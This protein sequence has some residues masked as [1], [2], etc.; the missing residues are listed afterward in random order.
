MHTTSAKQSCDFGTMVSAGFLKALVKNEN[1]HVN[2]FN[3]GMQKPDG[4]EIKWQC[5]VCGYTHT[6]DQPPARCPRCGALQ[7][8][9]HIIE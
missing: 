9:F 8:F 6:G 4:K 1:H 2:Q 5:S 7:K 3:K